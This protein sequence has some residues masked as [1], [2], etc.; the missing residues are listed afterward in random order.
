MAESKFDTSMD[1]IKAIREAL[2]S[3]PNTK[4]DSE[5]F[6]N[7]YDMCSE[8]GKFLKDWK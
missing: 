8:I 5:H 1:I 7:T 2:N 6:V 4:V 3:M